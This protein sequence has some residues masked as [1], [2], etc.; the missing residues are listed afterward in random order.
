MDPGDKNLA[1]L[2]WCQWVMLKEDFG[3]LNPFSQVNTFLAKRY[4]WQINIHCMWDCVLPV[5]WL[6]YFI[7]FSFSVYDCFV[8]EEHMDSQDKWLSKLMI[9]F[10]SGKVSSGLGL[11]N[12]ACSLLQLFSI[13]RTSDWSTGNLWL[14]TC[15]VEK[16]T[17]KRICSERYLWFLMD[18]LVLFWNKKK[19]HVMWMKTELN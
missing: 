5:N 9:A 10:L 4:I 3:T 2:D 13:T 7:R 1:Y 16:K 6:N 11:D 15:R 19:L 8:K 17:F 18:C 14:W 12:T